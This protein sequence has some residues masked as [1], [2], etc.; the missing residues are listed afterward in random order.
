MW[1]DKIPH[2]PAKAVFSIHHLR[3][4]CLGWSGTTSSFYNMLNMKACDKYS[5]LFVSWFYFWGGYFD[6]QAT[7]FH[8]GMFTFWLS[9]ELREA[10]FFFPP[11]ST[12]TELASCHISDGDAPT[13]GVFVGDALSQMMHTHTRTLTLAHIPLLGGLCYICFVFSKQCWHKSAEI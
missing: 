13:A 12:R 11:A 6:I 7:H 2:N 10:L 9:A 4:R 8:F 3:F 5:A 1:F